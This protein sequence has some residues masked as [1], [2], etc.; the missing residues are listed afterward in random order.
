MDAN[1][2]GNIR[3]VSATDIE[4][5]RYY[6]RGDYTGDLGVEKSYEKA[7][8]GEKGMEILMKDAYGRIK[9]KYENGIHD[10]SPKSGRNG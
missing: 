3:E 6:R 10:I 5:D 9:G 7:L 2:L 8:R 4:K 1:I